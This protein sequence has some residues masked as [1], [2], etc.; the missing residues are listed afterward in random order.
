MAR[1]ELKSGTPVQWFILLSLFFL[2]MMSASTA[3]CDVE[4]SN[5]AESEEDAQDIPAVELNPLNSASAQ[6]GYRFVT[7]DG[8]LAAASPYGRLKSGVSGGFSA[9]SLGSDLKLSL[10]GMFLHEDDYHT[11]L[12][13]DYSGYYRLHVESGVLWH[14]LLSE[15]LPPSNNILNPFTSHQDD[16]GVVY[17]TRISI[18]QVENRIKLGDNPFHLNL[19]YWQ[20]SREGYEQLRFSDHF[21]GGTNL[22]NHIYSQIS[23]VDHVTR[24]GSV[25]LDGHIKWFDLAY[26]FLIRDFSN[27]AQD[28]RFQLDNTGN[29][30][31]LPGFQAHDTIPNNRV[32]SHSVKL[33]SD[34]SG[35]LAGAAAYTLTQRENNGGHG[36]AQPSSQPKDTI[37]NYAGDLSYT[38]FKKISFALKYRHQEIDR[39]TPLNVNYPF[40]AAG[41]LQVRPSPD[42]VKDVISFSSILRPYP[43]M[44]YRLEYSAE[45]ESRDNV[46]DQQ[47]PVGPSIA[48]PPYYANHSDS[49]QTHTGKISF[50]W[51]PSIINMKVNASYSYAAC[52]N[53][54]YGSSFADQ[55][56]GKLLLTYTSGKW[57]LTGSYLAE[58]ESGKSSAWTVPDVTLIV[59]ESAVTFD[60]PRTSRNNSTNFS[61]WFNPLERLTVTT[62]YSFLQHDTDQSE[63]L[64]TLSRNAL[65][66]ANYRSSS[67]VYGLDALYT[68]SEQLDLSLGFQ[69]IRSAARFNVPP[70]SSFSTA[71]NTFTTAGITDLTRLD[72]TETGVS[73]RADWRITALLG[74]ALDYSFR[75]YDSGNSA[76]DGSVHTTMLNLKAR[77]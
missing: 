25:G 20:L 19:G 7:P 22:T 55:H 32:T 28:N 8:P 12:F 56:S 38:P 9:A 67:H 70:G 58:Y 64:T 34:L 77:W 57:G 23:R 40:A 52:D 48:G 46:R 2:F 35:G 51:R 71:T 45:L 63:L 76:Y 53:P 44:I 18:S 6:A 13:L 60:L 30:A 66:A 39:D 36:D 65:V 5:E 42:S 21:N 33:Y 54:A 59:P 4:D 41:V 15:A 24:E 37:Q 74:C 73:A 3:L 62:S 29:G 10:N 31:S 14:N 17:G 27:E 26:V 69:Q 11:E 16:A 47:S 72:T 50:Y 49:R 43:K 75:L 61:F 68:A 1:H